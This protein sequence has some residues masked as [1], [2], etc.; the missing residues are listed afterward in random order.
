MAVDSVEKVME[1]ADAVESLNFCGGAGGVEAVGDVGA[2]GDLDV[3]FWTRLEEIHLTAE[4]F[5]RLVVVC[6]EDGAEGF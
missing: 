3:G 5:L 1:Q 4:K 2:D 6:F